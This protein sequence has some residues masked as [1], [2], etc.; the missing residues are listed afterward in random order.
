MLCGQPLSHRRVS[1]QGPN[2]PSDLTVSAHCGDRLM[3]VDL[4]QCVRSRMP[5]TPL[6]WESWA[7]TLR[8]RPQVTRVRGSIHSRTYGEATS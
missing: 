1:S 6:S 3:P 5:A 2:E 8:D 7:L 4:T